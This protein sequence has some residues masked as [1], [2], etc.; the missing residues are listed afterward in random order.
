MTR[1]KY[2]PNRRRKQM[3]DILKL[4]KELDGVNREYVSLWE[5]MD[6]IAQEDACPG[7]ITRGWDWPTLR[8]CYPEVAARMME[9]V[10][11]AK[12][13]AHEI[14]ETQ[15]NTLHAM[16]VEGMVMS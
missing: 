16:T 13:I 11:R 12:E 1:G 8:M 15:D 10:S 7:D 9:L 2:L 6:A 4:R 5:K 3:S 14:A